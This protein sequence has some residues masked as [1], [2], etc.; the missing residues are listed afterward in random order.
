MSM[1]Q[2]G[3]TRT[4]A[5]CVAA[6]GF[7]VL[8]ALVFWMYNRRDGGTISGVTAPS[9]TPAPAPTDKSRTHKKSGTASMPADSAQA[10]MEMARRTTNAAD[11]YRIL[12]DLMARAGT[13]EKLERILKLGADFATLTAEEKAELR[14]LAAT[15]EIREI[16]DLL[17]E[18]S[19]K[20]ACD[21]NL[22]YESGLNLQLPHIAPLRSL[23]RLTGILAL[24]AGDQ[25]SL[26][27]ACEM[28][29][30]GLSVANS[31][32]SDTILISQLVQ[33]A[34]D[35]QV[36]NNL[37]T[38]AGAAALPE[39]QAYG[40]M[41]EIARRDY[42]SGMVASMV[43]EST[44]AKDLF[45]KIAAGDIPE[46]LNGVT[47]EKLR[48]SAY[49]EK[50]KAK[51]EAYYNEVTALASKPYDDAVRARLREL[52]GNLAGLSDDEYGLTRMMIPSFSNVLK[53]MNEQD[54]AVDATLVN[55]ATS[56]YRAKYGREPAG[57]DDLKGILDSAFRQPAP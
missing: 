49:L 52:E 43:S 2:Q 33:L 56:A 39:E 36:L 10:R 40:L 27:S 17:Q 25:G 54:A 4:T 20:K 57:S 32:R 35:K 11:A 47:P 13:R 30:L 8:L 9:G 22:D 24:D 12:F 41:A 1:P 18:A 48:D 42:A 29:G 7:L 6:G 28:A 16:V 55:L 26:K 14:M 53:R 45:N 37:N 51:C 46:G 15:P 19:L 34:C 50:N 23:S 21:F 38:L 31:L 5:I 3:R 44:F